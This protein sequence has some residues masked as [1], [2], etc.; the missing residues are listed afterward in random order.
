MADY[1]SATRAGRLAYAPLAGGSASVQRPYRMALAHLHAAGIAWLPGLAAVRACP[2]DERA[3]LA[4]QFAGGYGCEPTSSMARLFDAVAALIGVRQVVG[5]GA[6]AVTELEAVAGLDPSPYAFVVAADPDGV[7]VAD[8]APVLRAIVRDLRARTSVRVIS[9][10]FHT[11]VANLAVEF[12]NRA[13]RTTGLSTVALTGDLFQNAR[14]LSSTRWRLVSA[15]F[16]VL[17][18][19]RVPPNDGGIAYGQLAVAAATWA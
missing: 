13:R 9:A 7:L 5:Y 8:P 12:A 10:R 4:E 2:P 16:E 3:V 14:L 11:A 18:H 19:T 15:G 1:R 17:T 6:Q